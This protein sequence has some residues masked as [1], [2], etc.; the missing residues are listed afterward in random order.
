METIEK[1]QVE[2]AYST[3]DL[4]ILM[5]GFLA[6]AN[7]YI[8]KNKYQLNSEEAFNQLININWDIYFN[9]SS[10]NLKKKFNKTIAR[11]RFKKSLRSL[12][13]TFHI[14]HTRI[15]AKRE[16]VVYDWGSYEKWTNPDFIE[17]VHLLYSKKHITIQDKRKKWKEAQAIADV[18]LKQYKDEKGDYYK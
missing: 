6:E 1:K 11:F 5:E 10:K 16:I 7:D 12:N 9:N 18:F 3:T 4:S 2:Y 8:K 14:I 15:L 13:R 17:K